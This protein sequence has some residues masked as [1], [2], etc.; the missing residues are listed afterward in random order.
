VLLLAQLTPLLLVEVVAVQPKAVAQEAQQDQIL[1][2]PPLHQMVV[3]VV[4]V[5]GQ[6]LMTLEGRV[7]LGEVVAF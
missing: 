1:F 6:R 5:L 2:F 3:E 7:A 4:V